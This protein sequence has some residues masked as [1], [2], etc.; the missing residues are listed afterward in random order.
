MSKKKRMLLA[1]IFFLAAWVTAACAQVSGPSG[2]KENALAARSGPKIK[3]VTTIFPLFDF[4]RQVGGERVAVE[5]LLP[6]G[7][8]PHTW[9]PSPRD[10]ARL[11]DARVF[12]Y[13]GAGMEP[14]ADRLKGE[15]TKKG[16]LVVEAAAG[17]AT[18]Q[19]TEGA[20]EGE[21]AGAWEASGRVPGADPHV[22]LDPVLAGEMVE[23]IAAALAE[24]DPA[25]R[26]TYFARAKDYGRRL[27]D[28]DAGYRQ[29]LSGFAGRKIVVSHAAFGYLARRYGLE[30][31]GI[32]GLVPDAEPD[33]RKMKEVAEICRRENVRYVFFE[34]PVSPR[35]AE[36]VAR[37]AGARTL[38]LYPLASLAPDQAAAGTGYIELMKENLAS[39]KTALEGESRQ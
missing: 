10:I 9:E 22:W 18:L 23:K 30:Q 35:L 31:V 38:P 25:G 24:A 20:G 21:G 8:E 28:L 39:L 19:E 4:A 16:V 5:M 29:A 2:G 11:Y 12:I 7:A 3:V 13:N 17:L 6:A 33:P 26:E 1:V 34:P 14:W 36:A 32:T 37:E 27:E 15:L